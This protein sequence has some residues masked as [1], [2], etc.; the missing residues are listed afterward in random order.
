[1]P[2]ITGAGVARIAAT[3]VLAALGGL[4]AHCLGLPVAWLLGPVVAI[5]LA[6]VAGLDTR[7]PP[8]FRQ[9]AFFILGI[10]AGSGVSPEAIG[11]LGLWPLSF[12]IQMVGVLAI[13][14]VTY[15]YLRKFVGW[16]HETALFASLP[17]ALAFVLA[18]ASE[19]RADMRSIIIVQT[20][21]LLLLIGALTPAL[22]WLEGGAD[23]DAVARSHGGGLDD[24]AILLG[25]SGALA[26]LGA[27]LGVPGGMMLGALIGSALLHGADLS[28]VS[29]PQPIAVP[30][31]IVL[32]A[33][34]GGRLH[35]IERSALVTLLPISLIAFLIGLAMSALAGAAAVLTLD[36][37][38][39]KVALAY[40]PGALEALT[41]LAFQ[42]AIDP[43]YVAAHHVVRF[44][45]IA[46][47]V[48]FLARRAKDAVES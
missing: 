17:G 35:G 13:V 40:A 31:L 2:T 8:V 36:L 7:L 16:S 37:G 33:L 20:V 10:Q 32:G 43:A 11:Q 18:A 22:G 26:L 41:V 3:L 6:S 42:F 9:V 30:C 5:S 14:V 45:G 15:L 1:M 29:V 44:M 39:G 25:V 28:A 47:V 21:R 23:V 46:F 24:Y 34:I 12:A 27:R 4:L 38:P 19:T 48:P